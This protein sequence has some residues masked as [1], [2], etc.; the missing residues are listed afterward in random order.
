MAADKFIVLRAN[1]PG[2][3]ANASLKMRQGQVVRHPGYPVDEAI[4]KTFDN[5]KEAQAFAEA[6]LRVYNEEVSEGVTTMKTLGKLS[7]K[8]ARE[9]GQKERELAAANA[10]VLTAEGLVDP[11]AEIKALE[12]NIA[13]Q[14]EE[15]ERLKS[16]SVDAEAYLDQSAKA[17]VK[18]VE[19]AAKAG[20]L[21][22]EDVHAIAEAEKSGKK[23][24]SVLEGLKKLAQSDALFGKL[25]KK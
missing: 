21:K 5:F 2:Q 19:K 18:R 3:L 15:I 23:R 12:E 9:P 24:S 10:K 8:N 14:K 16:Q 4:I 6:Q 11:K 17:A 13:R 1:G 20:K 22:K 7:A 25:F